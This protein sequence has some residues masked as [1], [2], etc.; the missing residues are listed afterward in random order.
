MQFDDLV[1]HAVSAHQGIP[2]ERI[3]PSERFRDLGL[4]GLDLV[5]VILRIE[6][7]QA[8]AFPM[9]R[10][11]TVETVEDLAHLLDDCASR[12]KS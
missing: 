3:S 1:R 7:V 2:L 10:L 12:T 11:E 9:E 5:L 6:D 8:I 4:T